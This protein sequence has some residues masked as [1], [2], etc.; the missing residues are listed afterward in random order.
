MLDKSDWQFEEE[1]GEYL[2]HLIDVA[3]QW[4]LKPSDIGICE[5]TYDVPLMVAY[6]RN[7][8]LRMAWENQVAEREAK[9]KK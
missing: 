3:H 2:Y 5:M 9:K 6:V 7:K 4:G 8:A 1:W